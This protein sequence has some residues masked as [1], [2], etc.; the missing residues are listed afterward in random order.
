MVKT[1]CHQSILNVHRLWNLTSTVKGIEADTM[2]TFYWIG[3]NGRAFDPRAV[4]AAGLF[5]LTSFLMSSTNILDNI[6]L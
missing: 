2:V 3:G 6:I 4:C 5:L 1:C